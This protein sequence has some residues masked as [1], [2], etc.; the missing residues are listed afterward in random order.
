MLHTE[1]ETEVHH[2]PTQTAL[3]EVPDQ[4]ELMLLEGQELRGH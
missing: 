3:Q 1:D 4:Q 2:N